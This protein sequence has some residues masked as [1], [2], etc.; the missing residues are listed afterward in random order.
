MTDSEPIKAENDGLKINTPFELAPKANSSRKGK[1]VVR[2]RTTENAESSATKIAVLAFENTASKTAMEFSPELQSVME[3][4]KRRTTQIKARL[5]ICSTAI[6]SVGTALSPLPI[7]ENKEFVDGIKV[8]L[9][10]VIGQFV[11]SGPGTTPPVLPARPANPLLPRASEI[12]FSNLSTTQAPAPK[13]TWATVA[14][15]DL[16]SSAGPST[17]KTAPPAPKAKSA[18]S[19]TT[20]DTRLFLRLA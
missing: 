17:K 8:Y 15:A 1:E 20:V 7:G 10:A 16:V 13:A 6:S 11:Q 4:E 14:R 19:R 9:R 18:N 3:A 2:E 5:A 12:R